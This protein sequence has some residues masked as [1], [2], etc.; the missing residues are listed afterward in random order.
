MAMIRLVTVE[1]RQSFYVGDVK[2]LEHL[3]QKG[4]EIVACAAMGESKL[5][6][7]LVRR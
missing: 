4:Y 2:E 7:T 1:V 5:I 6:Y 3:L